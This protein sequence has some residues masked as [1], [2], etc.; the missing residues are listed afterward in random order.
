W[1]ETE[2]TRPFDWQH[3]PLLRV[4]ALRRTDQTFQ[5][6]LSFHHAI[7]DGWSLAVLLSELLRRYSLALTGQA[8]ACPEPP[9]V[10]Y[11]AFVELERRT[12]AD[13]AARAFWDGALR[14]AVPTS[15]PRWPASH[16]E[17]DAPAPR[18]VRLEVPA[19]TIAGLERLARE[20]GAP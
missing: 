10:P 3:A 4:S 16:D 12:I 2:K 17:R 6:G 18:E 13:P 19:D 11:R 7:L 20:A 9:V 14:Y 15:L 5:L 1:T 8:D